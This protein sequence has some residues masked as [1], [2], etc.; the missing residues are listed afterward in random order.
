MQYLPRFFRSILFV[1][2]STLLGSV[3]AAHPGHGVEPEGSGVLHYL[4]SPGHLGVVALIGVVVGAVWLMVR[5]L[6][7]KTNAVPR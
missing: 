2:T 1:L 4:L 7:G 5:S 3:A 6:S